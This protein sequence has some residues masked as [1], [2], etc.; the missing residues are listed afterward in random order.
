MIFRNRH[1]K[2]IT[3]AF[4]FRIMGKGLHKF[5]FYFIKALLNS[6]GYYFSL[7][8]FSFYFLNAISIVFTYTSAFCSE[9]KVSVFILE[10]GNDSIITQAFLG[11]KIRKEFA[12]ILYYSS[13][14]CSE[15][16]VSGFI[17]EN[18]INFILV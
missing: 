13:A 11:G 15:P 1:N 9:P 16:D 18:R 14:V 2:I 5:A 10:D 17:F 3:Q 6:I 12:V 8:N 7:F 4:H